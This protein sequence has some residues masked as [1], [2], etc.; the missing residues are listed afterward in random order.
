MVV[1]MT[2]E[3]GITYKQFPFPRLYL[4]NT[5]LAGFADILDDSQR[6]VKIHKHNIHKALIYVL[7]LSS[8]LW[9]IS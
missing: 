3:L 1:S 9:F 6:D 4:R 2:I 8:H 5:L 7:S